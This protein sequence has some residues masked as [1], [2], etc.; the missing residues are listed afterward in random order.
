MSADLAAGGDIALLRCASRRGTRAPAA[1][2]EGLHPVWREK[3]HERYSL[4]PPTARASS[5][6]WER[7]LPPHAPLDARPL[8][9]RRVC[10]SL[11][12]GNDSGR[13]HIHVTTQALCCLLPSRELPEPSD[14]PVFTAAPAHCEF[15]WQQNGLFRENVILSGKTSRCSF[16]AAQ[17]LSPFPP[18]IN[19]IKQFTLL[20]L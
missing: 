11:R 2:L 1:I 13:K 10:Q 5:F 3:K 20:N 6:V 7:K 8:I 16:S 14:G 15:D 9:G 4:I 12:S 19:I 17:T 18:Q